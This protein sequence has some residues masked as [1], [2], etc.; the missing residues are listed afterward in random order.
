MSPHIRECHLLMSSCITKQLIFW[1][2]CIYYNALISSVTEKLCDTILFSNVV[3]HKK[4]KKCPVV[5]I[6][7]MHTIFVFMCALFNILLFYVFCS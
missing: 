2:V 5:V 7:Q 4:P 3:N 6:L 1:L